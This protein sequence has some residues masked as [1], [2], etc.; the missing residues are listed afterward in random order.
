MSSSITPADPADGA[1]QT[2]DEIAAEIEA[3][4]ARLAENVDALS[5][6]LDVK[7]QAKD[8]VHEATDKVQDKASDVKDKVFGAAGSAT[9]SST[10]R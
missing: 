1:K 9:G 5:D 3:T 2:P 8:K 7:A 6:K 10:L 4:R